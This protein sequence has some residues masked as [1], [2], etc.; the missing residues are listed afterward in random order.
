MRRA[1][2]CRSTSTRSTPRRVPNST[3]ITNPAEVVTTIT[4]PAG[5]RGTR[6]DSPAPM[7]PPAAPISAARI[8]IARRSWV[9][10]RA[11]AAGVISR[12]TIRIS[13]TACSPITV[14]AT[15]RAS[16]SASRSATGKPC[17]AAYGASK[18]SRFSSLNSSTAADHQDH[19]DDG[20]QQRVG[21]QHRG[22]LAVNEGV[23]AGGGAAAH[24]LD[25]PEQRYADAER[26]RQHDAQ[27]RILVQTQHAAQGQ[28][29]ADGDQA[30]G[31]GAKQQTRKPLAG[32]A[33][34]D[35]HQP[36]RGDAGQRGVADR[37]RHQGAL[38]QQGKGAD[39][40][41]RHPEQGDAQ[42][43]HA[44]VEVAQEQHA[45]HLL[46]GGQ[47]AHPSRPR[48]PGPRPRASTARS[49]SVSRPP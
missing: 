1:P 21:G 38:A 37:V 3:L 16:I 11:A 33:E 9:Q 27:G 22:G 15:T 17:V 35:H 4:A 14:T 41:R 24:L 44:R 45:H 43:H 34:R 23:Q 10:K 47:V 46:P 40:A 29:G 6:A 31:R 12:A 5:R 8:V 49:S 39:D 28:D 48:P 19:R 20:D 42:H 26:H 32:A 13:P 18:H 30:A 36:C 7:N 25:Q 2:R